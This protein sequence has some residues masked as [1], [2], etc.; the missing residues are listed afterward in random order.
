MAEEQKKKPF[1]LNP[2]KKG[3]WDGKS[4]EE[5]E[6]ALAAA[7]KSGDVTRE[8]EAVFALN[9]KRGKFRKKK[10]KKNAAPKRTWGG[11]SWGQHGE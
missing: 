5:I 7:K 9:A 1:K 4:V 10:K 2:K 6:T 11:H 3:M 8:R